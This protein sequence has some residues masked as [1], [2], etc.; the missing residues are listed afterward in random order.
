[1]CTPTWTN[2]AAGSALTVRVD[3]SEDATVVATLSIN[4]GEPQD[5]PPDDF[6]KRID[7]EPQTIYILKIQLVSVGRPATAVITAEVDG[8]DPRGP[9][10]C[11][12]R[13]DG[14]SPIARNKIT[15]EGE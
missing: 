3:A 8:T 9:D 14:G 5:I 12:L 10:T 13:V 11:N 4:G 15:V 1:M 7:I 6:P 2:V